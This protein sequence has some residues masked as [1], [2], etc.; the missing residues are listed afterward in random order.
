MQSIDLDMYY[1]A[2]DAF[3]ENFNCFC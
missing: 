2:N 3:R 1:N